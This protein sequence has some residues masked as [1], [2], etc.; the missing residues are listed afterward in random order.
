L[1]IY[2]RLGPAE[3]AVRRLPANDCRIAYWIDG[4]SAT[5]FS[6]QINTKANEANQSSSPLFIAVNE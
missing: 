2:G 1:P 6:L 4:T 5:A 3:A